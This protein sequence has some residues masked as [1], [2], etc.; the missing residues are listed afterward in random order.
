MGETFREIQVTCPDCSIVKNV[1]IPEK[2]FIQKKFG[3]IKI[4]IPQG[5]VCREHQF[6]TFIDVKGVIRGY[7]RIDLL[8]KTTI[9]D[10]EVKRFSLKHFIDIFGLYGVFCLIHAKIFNYPTYIIKDKSFEDISNVINRIGNNLLPEEYQGTVSIEF[11]DETD[12]TKIKL[13]EKNAFVI[14]S[15]R[16]ILQTPWQEKVKF[17][18]EIIKK[19]LDIL[20]EDEQM[21]LIQQNILKFIRE[22]KYVVRV[23]EREKEIFE[24]DL[25][26]QISRELMIPKPNR[27]RMSL[28]K[29]F[30]NQ[31]YSSKLTEKI[32]TKVEE[33][34]ELL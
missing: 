33:F 6:V 16:R 32:K 31:R 19:A 34:L 26:E 17:E 24:K 15:H 25:M 28:I 10:Q 21:L 29:E 7:D 4:Q 1:M 30:I 13:K 9:E 11:L 18:E 2:L 8:M 12:Y 22:A 3:I 14:D 5:G 20:D 27:Y 23:L